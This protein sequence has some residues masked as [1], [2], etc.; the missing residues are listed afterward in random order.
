VVEDV[1]RALLEGHCSIASGAWWLLLSLA[2]GIGYQWWRWATTRHNQPRPLNRSVRSAARLLSPAA[3]L[4][5]CT[6]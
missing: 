2:G 3:D 5:F 1:R 4:R 6:R